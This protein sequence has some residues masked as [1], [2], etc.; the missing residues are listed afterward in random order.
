MLKIKYYASLSL[1]SF[2]SLIF[3]GAMG[4]AMTP[5]ESTSNGYIGLGG[6]YN[7]VQVTQ[8]LYGIGIANYSGAQLGSGFAEGPAAPFF[9]TVNTFAPEVQT[10]WYKH[11]TGSDHLWGIK[12]SYQYLGAVVNSANFTVPQIGEK[13]G[14]PLEGNLLVGGTQTKLDH[15]LLLLPYIGHSFKKSQVYLGV[16]PAV[17]GTRTN[18]NNA[19]GFANFGEATDVTGLPISFSNSAWVWGGAAQAGYSYFLAPDWS[20]DFDYTY[21]ISGQYRAHNSAPFINQIQ[22]N[23]VTVTGT[24]IVNTNQNIAA[25]AFT[26]SINKVF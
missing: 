24:G 22:N 5:D 13:N 15:E 1:L 20:V 10:G 7:S 21:A 23:T 18:I 16:G 19:V 14:G 12:F 3:A 26:V 6:S 4:N 8:N 9:G 25:Q 17:F 2:S 11:F